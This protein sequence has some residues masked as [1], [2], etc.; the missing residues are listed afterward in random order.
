MVNTTVWMEQNYPENST[1]TRVEDTENYG[2]NRSQIVNLDVS[3]QSLEGYLDNELVYKSGFPN[4]KK[5]NAS[6]NQL[7]YA[8]YLN[9]LFDLEELDLSHNLLLSVGNF[10]ENLSIKK[11]NF[12]FNELSSLSVNYAWNLTHLDFSNNLVRDFEFPMRDF[13][14]FKTKGLVY[15]NARSNSLAELN[16][17]AN[18]FLNSLDCSSNKLT[19]LTLNSPQINYLDVSNNFLKELDLSLIANLQTLNCSN[20][21]NLAS[22]TLT[23]PNNFKPSVL[24]C[25]NTSLKNITFSNS[26]MFDCETGQLLSGNV[27]IA[28]TPTTSTTGNGLNVGEISGIV[29]G[30][31]SFIVA[32]IGVWLTYKQLKESRKR[33]NT[34]VKEQKAKEEAEADKETENTNPKE[35]E[36][37]E[38]ASMKTEIEENNEDEINI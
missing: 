27:T 15:L 8:Q 34:Q 23:L 3:K 32:V 10:T 17:T 2:K 35:E 38:Q 29:V 22:S 31:L 4:L 16:L 9:N 1:C 18:I 11:L 33:K 5:L 36:L 24:D 12:S 13:E 37:E 14:F 30:I 7:N 19:K 21:W 28:N 20:N 26:S 6:F 25:S